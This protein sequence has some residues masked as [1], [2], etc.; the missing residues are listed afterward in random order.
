LSTPFLGDRMKFLTGLRKQP[1]NHESDSTDGRLGRLRAPRPYEI[2]ALVV[3]VL[4]LTVGGVAFAT[5]PSNG[6]ITGCY[7]KSG[8][9]LRVIDATTSNC[10]S[11]ETSLSWNVQG[12]PGP[13]GSPG[14]SGA[15]GS[16]GPSGAPGSPG[17]SGAPGSPGISGYEVV[18]AESTDIDPFEGNRLDVFAHCPVGKRFLGGTFTFYLIPPGFAPQ[19]TPADHVNTDLGTFNGQDSYSVTVIHAI[20]AGDGAKLVAKA[21][22]AIVAQ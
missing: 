13:T 8:G 4:A 5:I 10:S 2:A 9:T 11:K 12:P 17:P 20:P 19:Y 14:P 22:C 6:V 1:A 16:P 21:T 3:A 18:T 7:Q 15:P